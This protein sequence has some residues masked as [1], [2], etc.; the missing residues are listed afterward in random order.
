MTTRQKVLWGLMSLLLGFSALSASLREQTVNAAGLPSGYTESY[1]IKT[2]SPLYS[3]FAHSVYHSSAGDQLTLTWY[4]TDTDNICSNDGILAYVDGAALSASSYATPYTSTC[5]G[6]FNI[7]KS[8]YVE[9]GKSVG[10]SVVSGSVTLSGY[11]SSSYSYTSWNAWRDWSTA[12]GTSEV[13]LTSSYTTDADSDKDGVSDSKD[14]CST[15][16]NADQKD[17][18]SDSMGDACDSYTCTSST[19]TGTYSGLSCTTCTDTLSTS[20]TYGKTTSFSCWSSGTSISGSNS[21]SVYYTDDTGN[22]CYEYWMGSSTSS[23]KINNVSCWQNT[24]GS[25]SGYEKY[26]KE[27]TCTS[28]T[29]SNGSWCEDCIVTATGATYTDSYSGSSSCGSTTGGGDTTPDDDDDDD[30]GD[31]DVITDC[32]T[33]TDVNGACV[34]YDI[35]STNDEGESC[36]LYTGW[37]D[38]YCYTTYSTCTDSTQGDLDCSTCKDSKGNTTSE[39]CWIPYDDNYDYDN[40]ENWSTYCTYS[41]EGTNGYRSKCYN[42]SGKLVNSNFWQ[43]TSTAT[44]GDDYDSS[45]KK[46]YQENATCEWFE[47]ESGSSYYGSS[48][49]EV[50][51]TPS[52]EV[53]D[54]GYDSCGDDSDDDWDDTCVEW[55]SRGN[56]IEYED[57][58][59]DDEDTCEVWDDECEED[60]QDDHWDDYYSVD[61]EWM[62]DSLDWLEDS[63]KQFSRFEK[64]MEHVIKEYEDANKWMEEDKEWLEEEGINTSFLDAIIA[65]REEEIASMEDDKSSIP[66]WYENFEL[67]VKAIESALENAPEELTSEEGDAY[68]LFIRK[69]DLFYLISSVFDMKTSV[70][71]MWGGYL[72][73][74]KEVEKTLARIG[75]SEIPDDIQDDLD[76][77]YGYQDEFVEARKGLMGS[78]TEDVFTLLGDMPAYSVED[79]LDNEELREEVRDFLDGDYW[80]VS[81]AF[82]DA[83][84]DI[85]NLSYD[86]QFMWDVA[87]ELYEVQWK[88]QSQK[89]IREEVAN[90]REDIGL[91]VEVFEMLEGKITDKVIAANIDDVLSITDKA[92]LMLDEIEADAENV[93]ADEME[94]F[95]SDLD[96]LGRYVQPRMEKV[97]SHVDKYES[98]LNLSDSEKDL[99]RQL[100]EM[101]QN[102]QACYDCGDRMRDVYDPGVVDIMENYVTKDTLNE[103]LAQIQASVIDTLVQYIDQEIAQKIMAAVAT[104]VDEFQKEKFGEDFANKLMENQAVVLSSAELIDFDAVNVGSEFN[105]EVK[106]LENVY[107]E[108]IQL[109]MPDETLAAEV[110]DHLTDVA[111]LINGDVKPTEGE[112]TDLIEEGEHW[113]EECEMSIYENHL[114]FKEEGISYFSD[115]EIWYKDAVLEGNGTYWEGTKNP[116]GSLTYMYNPSGI[117]GRNE[118]LKMVLA[119]Y[120]YS[121]TGGGDNW[122]T[123]WENTGKNLGLGL[124][125]KDLTQIITR[126]EAMRLI[127]EVGKFDDPGAFAKIF[128]DLGEGDDWKPALALYYAD[129][130]T[131]DGDTGNVRLNETLNRAEMAALVIRTVGVEETNEWAE[132]GGALQSYNGAVHVAEESDEERIQGLFSAFLNLLKNLLPTNLFR[133]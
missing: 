97:L 124:V 120:G 65:A 108:I 66:D 92:Y 85:W 93:D 95:W 114:A 84:N 20:S 121:E 113:L 78:P 98:K 25:T 116:D 13:K 18:D 79:L 74:Q 19:G 102:D 60:E 42:D 68:N 81:D 101:F 99:L 119:A 30:S 5:T 22:Y 126:G 112:L 118:A 73:W 77:A 58:D 123:G 27:V 34:G 8:I 104:H 67:T 130:V 11:G 37:T 86:N 23:Y 122:W 72:E 10:A 64:R 48:W 106:E 75:D 133:F 7:G 71:Q 14:N 44:T 117:T 1:T 80:D 26:A 21:K 17:S 35:W 55:D 61:I 45:W 76:E 52:G 6:T 107:E 131:G 129:I 88:A 54:L 59:E 32:F 100:E 69:G 39:S 70:P 33:W 132:D 125:Q 83:Q 31:G 62:W 46:K 63:L 128:P 15:T 57:E 110:A 38:L 115:T 40:E 56:C 111:T 89:W 87:N 91:V 43:Y 9:S 94:D 12:V 90:M 109:P 28:G 103:L 16:S 105:Q 50:C 4:P 36:V 53:L 47:D 96:E 82:Y 24:S 49:C 41:L 51:T 29:K 127:Y 2:Y 3:N